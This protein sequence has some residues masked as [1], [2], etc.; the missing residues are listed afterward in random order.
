MRFGSDFSS[1]SVGP[2]DHVGFDLC[3]LGTS[4]HTVITY[5][6]RRPEAVRGPSELTNVHLQAPSA[7]GEPY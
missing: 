4:H 1:Q 7:Y 5:G 3:V 2:D 6:K